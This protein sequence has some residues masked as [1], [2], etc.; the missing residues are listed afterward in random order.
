MLLGV[1]ARLRSTWRR[2]RH[3][4]DIDREMQ[5]EMR[6]H[7]E[8]ET[9][10]LI[11]EQGLSH[12][13]AWRQAHIRF[14][15]VE[16]YREAGRDVRTFRWIDALLLDSRF[17]LRMLIKHRGLSLVGAF[18]MAVAIAVGA[19]MFEAFDEVLDTS[20][21]FAGGE[22]VVALHYVGANPGNP[23]RQ[24]LHDFAALRGQ[25]QTIEHFG[26]FRD[27]QHNLV[28]ANT[29]PEPVP[30]AEISASAFALTGTAALHGRYLLPSDE[31]E[32]APPVAVIGY[33]A[34][35]T[36]WGGSPDVV[37]ETISLGGVSRIV[38]GVMPEGFRFPVNH[39]FWIPFQEDPLRFERWEG[40]SIRM[41]GRLA[42]GVTME[43]AQAEFAAVAQRTAV[44]H[45]ETR[46]RLRA[47]VLPYTREASDLGSPA[48]LWAMRLGQLFV[49]ALT[50]VVAV[51][52]AILIYA[53][54]VTRLGEIAVRSALG[55]SRARIL[56]QLFTEALALSLA[57]AGAGL[58]L[59][60]FALDFIQGLNELNGGMP[61]WIDYELSPAAIVYSLGLSV[62]AA[63]IMGVLPG[64]KATGLGLNANLHEL[65][66]RAGTRLGPVWTALIVAQVAVAVA[67]LPAAVYIAAQVVRMEA[68]GPGF[69]A[70]SVAVGLAGVD[71]EARDADR[72]R[73]T[74]RQQE[75]MTR[76]AAE[77]GVTGVTFSSNLPG[78]G[79]SRDIEFEPGTRLS[80]MSEF[81]PDDDSVD[82]PTPSTI[83][84]GAEMF[85]V[86][87]V[88]ILAGR[89][90][91]ASDVGAARNVIVN[92]S[93]A[94]T[95]LAD[96]NALGA[97][98][99]YVRARD[100]VDATESYQIVGVVRD[101]PSFPPNLTRDGEPTIYHPVAAG[102]IDP[103]ML[104]VR[105][106][107]PVPA[108]FVDRFRAIGAEVD[109]ALQLRR[110][111]PLADRY[112][113]LRT[114]WRSLA[115][116]I[117]LVTLSVLLLSAAGIYALMSF[118]VA[119]RT[120][121]IGIRTALG[122]PPGRVLWSVF[123]RAAR[124]IVAGVIVGTVI[125]GAGFIA[126]GL[127][128]SRATPLLAAVAAIMLLVGLFAAFGPARRGLRIQAS[129]ALRADA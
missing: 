45:P 46:Q 1:F 7:V 22:R 117:A 30:V 51:N 103:V 49:G 92:R 116:A 86:Y 129:E 82:T 121:E 110:V 42:E 38:V 118:T 15:G 26:A 55:A 81:V 43:Q 5:D 108:G 75:L 33:Q 83:D 109:P 50:F 35:H 70:E 11:R 47:V 17:G 123:A 41:F 66:G 8:M 98:F 56:A 73:V 112:A 79:G 104:S 36:R 28:A 100:G 85:Q 62:L 105:F 31:A 4:P 53:R 128:L 64:L 76:L 72:T 114:V 67:V 48:L 61:F 107:G 71:E 120:R 91:I 93:F 29:A 37:G 21:P 68:A 99:R 12:Q 9:E 111:G 90:F 74:Q 27:V 52:L 63:L 127:G 65:N 124:Q 78:F 89:D 102:S 122:A 3:S 88:K 18:A 40:P 10:R 126:I 115:W 13:E 80:G 95:Y 125:S 57:G 96:G 2:L 54:T 19:S 69:A 23:E 25:L 20:L 113:E 32:S 44:V 94:D 24:V 119:Q 59:A 34:W 106:A 6:F 97:R 87:G 58:V 77:P 14:G 16:K 101:F 84:V 60:Y 39:Q